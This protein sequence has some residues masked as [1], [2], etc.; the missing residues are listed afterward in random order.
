M[1]DKTPLSPT[2]YDCANRAYTMTAFL[3]EALDNSATDIALKLSESDRLGRKNIQDCINRNVMDV[4]SLDLTR[5][6]RE[7]GKQ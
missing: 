4:L 5:S 2:M 3:S 7:E 6:A 1:N